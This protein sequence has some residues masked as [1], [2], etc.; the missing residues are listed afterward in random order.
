MAKGDRRE[1][2][3]RK[4][5]SESSAGTDAS[6]VDVRYHPGAAFQEVEPRGLLDLAGVAGGSKELWLLQLPKPLN[7]HG[8]HGVTIDL[9]GAGGSQPQA[10]ALGALSTKDGAKFTAV[11]E[12]AQQSQ[13]LF[14]VASSSAGAGGE[15]VILPVARRVTLER[16]EEGPLPLPVARQLPAE[17][18][19]A[20]AREH[21]QPS[22]KK[23]KKADKVLEKETEATPGKDR[24]RDRKEGKEKSHKEKS[25]K[26]DKKSKD[27][28]H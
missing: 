17:A 22:A 25:A 23:A 1:A 13:Q 20:P 18:G 9:A 21:D 14:M 24:K 11:Q 5:L 19:A 7:C 16:V 26:K 12:C 4:S 27:R 8:L 28:E 3:A 15:L 2:K 10:H 6:K